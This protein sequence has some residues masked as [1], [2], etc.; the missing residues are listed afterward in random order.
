MRNYDAPLLADW[1]AIFFRWL[2]LI[3]A[4]IV[5]GLTGWFTIFTASLVAVSASWERDPTFLAISNLRLSSYRILNVVE[6]TC[7]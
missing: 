7:S 5:A 4:S 1:Y 6:S 3:I 2:T